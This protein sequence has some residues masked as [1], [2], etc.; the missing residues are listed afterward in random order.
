MFYYFLKYINRKKDLYLKA[1]TT[2]KVERETK[3]NKSKQM[4]PTFKNKL[5]AVAKASN[6][7]HNAL[8]TDKYLQIMKYFYKNKTCKT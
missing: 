5:F 7:N 3:Q 8:L 1:L 4:H 6:F 2:Q